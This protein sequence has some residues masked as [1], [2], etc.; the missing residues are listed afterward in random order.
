MTYSEYLEMDYK[1]LVKAAKKITGNNELALDLLHYSICELSGK[2]KVQEIVDSGGARFYLLRVM[3]T[4]WRSNTGPFYLNYVNRAIELPEDVPDVR[5]EH[6]DEEDAMKVQKILSELP[7]YEQTLFKLFVEGDHT[8]SSLS[9][10]T[11]IPRTSI[12][13]TVKRVRDHVKKI[14]KPEKK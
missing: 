13:F 2:P 10:E 11:M 3:V 5:D 14:L 7:W 4:Q 9:E 12:S 1:E 8:Y 6:N